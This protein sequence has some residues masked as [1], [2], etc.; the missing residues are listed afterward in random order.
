MSSTAAAVAGSGAALTAVSILLAVSPGAAAWYTPFV[1]GSY[2]LFGTLNAT[3]YG[4]STLLVL[5]HQP[6]RWF[7]LYSAIAV[8]SLL[9]DVPVGRLLGPFWSYPHL[10]LAEQLVHVWLIGYPFGLLSAAETYWFLYRPIPSR[11]PR[12]GATMKGRGSARALAVLA[13]LDAVLVTAAVALGTSGRREGMQ[14]ALAP[15]LLL[16]P[17]TADLTA[18]MRGRPGLVAAALDRRFAPLATT[19]LFSGVIG[20]LHEVPNTW[21]GEWVYCGIPLTR[22]EVLGVNALVLFPGWFFLLMI[23]LVL[24]NHVL[25]P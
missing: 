12:P 15:L 13:V 14:D 8:V 1:L 25:P 18:T 9:V 6:R 2:L 7:R 22:A 23:A 21:A 3:T 5:R 24:T 4:A 10:S 11:G 19:V 20:V 16:L 17:L